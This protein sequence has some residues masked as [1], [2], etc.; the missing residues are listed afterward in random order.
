[1]KRLSFAAFAMA[2]AILPAKAAELTVA[3]AGDQNM[4]DYIN[5]YLGPLFEKTYPGNTVRAVGTGAAMPVRKRSWS[6]STPSLPPTPQSGTRTWPWFMR[7][8]SARW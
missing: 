4:V 5:Q 8:L 6:V 1:M 2:A 7:S 3:T